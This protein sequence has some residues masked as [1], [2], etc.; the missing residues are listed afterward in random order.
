M[1]FWLIVVPLNCNFGGFKTTYLRISLEYQ[2]LEDVKPSILASK[3][4]LTYTL[5]GSWCK[6]TSRMF[7][8]TFFKV[9][10]VKS[11]EMLRD[12]WWTLSL[13][14]SF[15][16]LIFLFLLTWATWRGYHHYW[17]ILRHEVGWPLKRYYICLG[18]LLNIFKVHCTSPQLCFSIPSGQY[19]CRGPFEQDYL[20][21]WSPFDLVSPSW[22]LG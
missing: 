21:F 3:P 2:P 19:P 22:A 12:L 11:Y 16:V 6:S 14:P 10:F 8:I 17:V 15:M 7:L 9:L 13:L 18:P 4:S 1:F 20:C 5:I